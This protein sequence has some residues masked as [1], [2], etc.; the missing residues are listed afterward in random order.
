[1]TNEF[2]YKSSIL[3]L[4]NHFLTKQSKPKAIKAHSSKATM[5]SSRALEY[6]SRFSAGSSMEETIKQIVAY[7]EECK[8]M[9]HDAEISNKD[10]NK[11][12][13]EDMMERIGALAEARDYAQSKL[14]PMKSAMP[15]APT[16]PNA[17]TKVAKKPTKVAGPR[18]IKK[19]APLTRA[20]AKKMTHLT[21]TEQ[22]LKSKGFNEHEVKYILR[23]QEEGIIYGA[24]YGSPD[25]CANSASEYEDEMRDQRNKYDEGTSDYEFYNVRVQA[26]K[27]VGQYFFDLAREVPDLHMPIGYDREDN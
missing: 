10:A 9:Y 23:F 5:V 27:I 13:L 24:E 1:M 22:S 25:T 26:L 16:K 18:I 8:K 20:V 12:Y 2:V 21:R 14:A 11:S 7:R 19:Y 17:T 4:H 3:T 6:V 15:F